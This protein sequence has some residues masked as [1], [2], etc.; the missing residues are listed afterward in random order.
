M[1][2]TLILLTALLAFVLPASSQNNPYELDD[3]CYD[4][5]I[6]AE[7]LAGKEGFK[8]VNE[9]LLQTAT[10]KQDKKAEVFYYICRLKDI[11]KSSLQLPADATPEVKA[12]ARNVRNKEVLAAHEDLKS[13]S[14][15]S[16]YMQYFYYS[17]SLVKNYYYNNGMQFQ[18][19]DVL[20]EM[21]EIAIKE[22]S[23]YGKWISALEMASLYEALRD[24]R[25]SRK[26]IKIVIDEY[27]NT[28]DP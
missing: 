6:Q 15:T 14:R 28:D 3:E 5:Y 17:Y 19:L 26:Y 24:V 13:I 1:R 23:P 21:R 18:A 9:A 7:T 2:K 12:E 4:L 22:D 8:E 25:T 20:K 11:I 16:G 27:E 10:A